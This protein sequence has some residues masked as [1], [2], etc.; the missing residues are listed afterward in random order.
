MGPSHCGYCPLVI[1]PQVD[2][3]HL[4]LFLVN[5]IYGINYVVAKG[6]MPAII[7]PSAFILLRVIG[8]GTNG[9]S[10]SCA[11][12]T[13]STASTSGVGIGASI[14]PPAVRLLP[15]VAPPIED[16]PEDGSE[17]PADT[18]AGD[19]QGPGEPGL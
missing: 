12:S 18:L 17:V 9:G 10:V 6:L 19:G 13:P 16:D 1:V 5:V 8:A 7:Q 14:V 3:A 15:A 2:L 4:A 11:Y